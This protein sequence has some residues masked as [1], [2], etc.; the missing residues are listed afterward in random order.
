MQAFGEGVQALIR[1]MQEVIWQI[2]AGVLTPAL[3]FKEG[4][5]QRVS[6]YEDHICRS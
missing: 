4:P 3:I 2:R 5:K 6:E 1:G